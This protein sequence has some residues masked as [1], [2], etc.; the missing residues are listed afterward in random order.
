MRFKLLIAFERMSFPDLLHKADV[1]NGALNSEPALTKLPDPWPGSYPSRAEIMQACTEF[2]T[3]HQAADD[4]G[5]S[6]RAD[7]DQKW[8]V[9]VRRLKD[10]A[11]Y[12]ESVAKASKDLRI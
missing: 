10:A 5:K 11:P 7:R 9:L 12:F 8:A 6:A 2:K 4:G 1:I 3:A